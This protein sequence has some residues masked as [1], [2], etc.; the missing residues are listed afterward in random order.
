MIKDIVIVFNVADAAHEPRL[1]TLGG[2]G[3]E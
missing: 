1:D 2:G 3:Q